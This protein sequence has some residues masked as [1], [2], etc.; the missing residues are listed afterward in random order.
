MRA[1]GALLAALLWGIDCRDAS[2]QG[3]PADSRIAP[4]LEDLDLRFALAIASQSC[5]VAPARA[6]TRWLLPWTGRLVPARD[7]ALATDRLTL[8]RREGFRLEQ[9]VAPSR[10]EG[11]Q[12]LGLLATPDS[13]SLK[14]PLVVFLH[15]SGTLPTQAFDER[16]TGR[17][18]L[19]SDRPIFQGMGRVLAN[20]GYQ[21]WAPLVSDSLSDR[22]PRY[23]WPDLEGAGAVLHAKRGSGGPLTLVLSSLQG[24]LDVLLREEGGTDRRV[25]VVGWKEGAFLAALLGAIDARV[26]A[27]VRLEPPLDAAALR[28]TRLG[29]E[30]GAPFSQFDCALT[31]ATLARW[32]A[33]K[34]LLFAPSTSDRML[35]AESAFRSDREEVAIRSAYA[36]VPGAV[37]V[38]EPSSGPR[39]LAATVKAFLDRTFPDSERASGPTPQDTTIR[40]LRVPYP[41]VVLRDIGDGWRQSATAGGSCPGPRDA[42]SLGDTTVLG[43]HTDSLRRTLRAALRLGA[44]P[45]PPVRVIRRDTVI[46]ADGYVLEFLQSSPGIGGIPVVGYLATPRHLDGP[47]PAVLS[48]DGDE[49]V[50]EPFAVSAIQRRAYLNS[51]GLELVRRG[52]VVFAPAIPPWF[53]GLATT[54]GLGRFGNGPTSWTWMLGYYQGGLDLLLAEPHVRADATG[55]YGISYAGYAALF[56]TAVDPRSRFLVFS[57]PHSTF[58]RLYREP[59]SALLAPWTAEICGWADATRI[60]MIAPRPFIWENGSRDANGYELVDLESVDAIS[61]FYNQLGIPERFRFLRHE[62]GHETRPELT[63]EALRALLPE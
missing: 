2:A 38:A 35:R 5:P 49:Y 9:V 57:N 62:H 13:L 3:A 11:V 31:P 42:P 46:V 55:A 10:L 21:L 40:S 4:V 63:V 53:P 51:Y 44:V 43:A 59:V 56:L 23:P 41:S 26:V 22:Y 20:A 54:I 15:G 19:S 6:D 27:V 47:R 16:Y 28:R 17:E 48:L 30:S 52:F 12:Q 50:G 7:S 33:P 32:L 61:A 60:Q 1:S 25:V 45:R 18:P 8:A 39:A 34:P 37:I 29:T 36:A 24:G 58:A 14:S